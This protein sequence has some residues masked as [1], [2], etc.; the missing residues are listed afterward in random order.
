MTLK[1]SY[2]WQ[3]AL[4]LHTVILRLKKDNNLSE[5][6]AD[7]KITDNEEDASGFIARYLSSNKTLTLEESRIFAKVFTKLVEIKEDSKQGDN[8]LY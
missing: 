6:L 8:I 3:L 7:V 4:A 2:Y 1:E 5:R